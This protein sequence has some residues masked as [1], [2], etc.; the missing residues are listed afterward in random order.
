MGNA[1]LAQVVHGSRGA[2]DILGQAFL[3]KF[4]VVA[5]GVEGSRWNG[6]HGPPDGVFHVDYVADN[7]GFFVLVLAHSKRWVCAP[8]P[9]K[10]FPARPPKKLLVL[11]IG[12]LGVGDG[13]LRARLQQ[14][15]FRAAG[16]FSSSP[17]WNPPGYQ[18]G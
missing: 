5:E 1:G 4:A 11:P 18:C 2:C 15:F 14:I 7:F 10:A 8:L 13:D 6:V 16:R 3:R 9:A 12:D 17:L